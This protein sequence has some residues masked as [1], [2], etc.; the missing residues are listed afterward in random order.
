LSPE[1]SKA[2]AYND[3]LNGCSNLYLPL[4]ENQSNNDATLNH[5]PTAH[6]Q[7]LREV[8]LPVM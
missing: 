4:P 8:Q 2:V 5:L 1:R 7:W 6:P 3:F